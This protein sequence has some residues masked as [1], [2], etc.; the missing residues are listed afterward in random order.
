[1]QALRPHVDATNCIHALARQI[2]KTQNWMRDADGEGLQFTRKKN[3]ECFLLTE[4]YTI[5]QV[6]MSIRAYPRPLKSY[7][8]GGFFDTS[9]LESKNLRAKIITRLSQKRFSCACSPRCQ[10][11]DSTKPN[12]DIEGNET[13][14]STEDIKVV[15]KV[16]AFLFYATTLVV[17]IPLFITL[18]IQHPFVMLLDKH[19]RKMHHFVNKIWAKITTYFFYK[20]SIEGWEN[21]PGSDDPAVYVA[22]HQ[23]FLDIYTLLQIGRPFKFISKTSNFVIPII[24][25]AMYLTGHVPL[26]RLDTKSQVECLR[27]CIQLLK[28]GVSVFFFPEGTRSTDGRMASFKKGAFVVASKGNVPVVPITLIGTGKLMPNGMEGTLTPGEV[29]VIIHPP[30]QGTNADV[31]CSQARAVIAASLP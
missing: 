17:A 23:S 12:I 27:L 20:V 15:P 19:R 8:T 5:G 11:A 13:I 30:I 7:Q 28:Q 10:F 14:F 29:K 26:R 2:P 31:L 6:V 16:R 3:A 1:M 24:G 18:L 22:N 21:L 4:S 9:L 25:W